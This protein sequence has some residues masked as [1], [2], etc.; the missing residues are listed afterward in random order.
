MADLVRAEQSHDSGG[1]SWRALIDPRYI[2]VVAIGAALF[3]FQQFA[4]INAVF[5][6]SSTVFQ[7]AGVTSDVAASVS[8]GAV[9]L[10]ASCLAAYLMDRLGRRTLMILSFMGM[11]SE[12]SKLLETDISALGLSSAIYMCVCID[13]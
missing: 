10:L 5:Y 6:F 4:G 8:V 2:K 11:V 1:T 3:A 7:A 9:N 13:L 12:T